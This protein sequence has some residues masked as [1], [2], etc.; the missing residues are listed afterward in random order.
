[1]LIVM[2]SYV[3]G[4]LVEYLFRSNSDSHSTRSEQQTVYAAFIQEDCPHCTCDSEE[5]CQARSDVGLFQ[6]RDTAMKTAE[7][8]FEWIF[9]EDDYNATQWVEQE[10]VDHW[11]LFDPNGDGSILAIVRP[12]PISTEVAIRE[13]SRRMSFT[14][15]DGDD[16]RAVQVAVTRSRPRTE[17]TTST[18]V[19]SDVDSLFGE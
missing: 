16:I 13:P 10:T 11:W 19:S 6:I 17:T 7:D 3:L 14:I 2:A 4:R 18:P 5:P 12:H 15:R 8:V 1:M 9:G